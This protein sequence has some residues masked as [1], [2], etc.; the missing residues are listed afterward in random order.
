M[1]RIKVDNWFFVETDT[2]KH[3]KSEVLNEATKYNN[4]EEAQEVV[5]RQNLKEIFETIIIEKIE[6]EL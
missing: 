2:L 6:E 3:R 1:Y 4:K 5:D